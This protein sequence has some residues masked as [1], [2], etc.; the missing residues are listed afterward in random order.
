MSRNGYSNNEY[1]IQFQTEQFLFFLI[2][3]LQN[4]YKYMYH[5]FELPK[6]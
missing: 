5:V 6:M 2:P 3:I 4:E 1:I